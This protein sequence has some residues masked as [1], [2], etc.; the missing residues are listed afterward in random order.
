VTPFRAWVVVAI[1]TTS[2]NLLSPTVVARDGLVV[3]VA[4]ERRVIALAASLVFLFSILAY[5][6]A[7]ARRRILL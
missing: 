6:R 2:V 4:E 5:R 7:K 1:A 3:I